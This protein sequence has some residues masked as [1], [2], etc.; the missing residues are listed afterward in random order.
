MCAKCYQNRMG[1]Y[2]E[3][4][5]LFLVDFIWIDPILYLLCFHHLEEHR[6][7]IDNH[8][9]PITAMADKILIEETSVLGMPGG[10]M[11]T[12]E[13]LDERRQQSKTI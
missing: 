5:G 2:R 11:P 3:H 6:Q 4:F 7:C 10:D 1:S 8:C 12:I 9:M 13:M